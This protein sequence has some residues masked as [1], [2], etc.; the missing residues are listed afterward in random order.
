[1]NE[2]GSVVYETTETVIAEEGLDSENV[3]T[4]FKS[5][6]S[7]ESSKTPDAASFEET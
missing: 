4:S 1:V 3:K 2:E 7:D 5:N 6:R